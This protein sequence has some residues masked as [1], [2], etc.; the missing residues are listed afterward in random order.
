MSKTLPR[1][2]AGY[3]KMRKSQLKIQQMAFMLVAVVLFFILAGVFYMV[4]FSRD[5]HTQATMLE[6]DNAVETANILA[7]SAEFSCGSYCIDADR[8]M[9]L[10]K[11]KAYENFWKVSSIEIRKVYPGNTEEV[12]C[13]SANYPNCNLI[14]VYDKPGSTGSASSFVSLCRREKEGGYVYYKCELAKFIVG[15]N[16]K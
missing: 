9:V 12:L 7:S 1:K 2:T 5:L 13:T 11:E 3:M 10:G 16:I 15:Y 8:A 6:K 14:K 4:I